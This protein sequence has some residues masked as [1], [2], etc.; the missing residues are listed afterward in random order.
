M[1]TRIKVVCA[2]NVQESRCLVFF[3]Q[4]ILTIC[5]VVYAWQ[6]ACLS[7][8]NSLEE[9]PYSYHSERS[10]RPCYSLLLDDRLGTFKTLRSLRF[11]YRIWVMYLV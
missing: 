7:E 9:M 1:T 4:C 11:Q 2:F 5:S 8:T 10:E 3:K 6:F